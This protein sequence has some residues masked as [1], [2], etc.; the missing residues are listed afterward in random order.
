VVGW[1]PVVDASVDV[2]N[3]V[4]ISADIAYVFNTAST[5]FP[6]KLFAG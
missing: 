6:H 2:T 5:A 3:W 4:G 1:G